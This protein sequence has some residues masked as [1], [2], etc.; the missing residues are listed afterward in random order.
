MYN[1][2]AQLK[3]RIIARNRAN[4]VANEV[5]RE[6]VEIF[7]PLVGEKVLKAD[8]QFLAKI[9]KLLPDWNARYDTASDK[10]T[11]QVYRYS[12]DYSVVF[13]VKTCQSNGEGGC[14]Y[15]ECSVYVADLNG[16][17]VGEKISDPPNA[18]T[19]FTVDEVLRLRANY[20]VKKVAADN[21]LSALFPFG[22][23]DR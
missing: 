16:T 19:D 6:L 22:E 12:S 23:N 17:S 9:A 8:G 11:V 20:A 5:Y 14:A 4:E 13:V 10:S 1:P 3:A 21:A 15:E 7:R 2:A 18:R